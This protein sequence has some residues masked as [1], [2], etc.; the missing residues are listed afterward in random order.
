MYPSC[1]ISLC[2]NCLYQYFL[3]IIYLRN[4]E[5]LHAGDKV[6]CE[7]SGDSVLVI[8]DSLCSPST[9]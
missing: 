5:S 4:L 1:L 2:V 3:Q 9:P 6:L 7:G 8:D